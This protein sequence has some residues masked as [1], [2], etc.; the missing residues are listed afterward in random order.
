MSNVP[1]NKKELRNLIWENGPSE[2]EVANALFSR[3]GRP[4]TT[5]EVFTMAYGSTEEKSKVWNFGIM[6]EK[7]DLI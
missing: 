1:E 6:R 7:R 3:Y 2:T 5:E 4:P